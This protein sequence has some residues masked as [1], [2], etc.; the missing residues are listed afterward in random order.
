MNS[1]ESS[2]SSTGLAGMGRRKPLFSLLLP[3][4]VAGGME[5]RDATAGPEIGHYRIRL[6]AD[7]AQRPTAEP[8]ES[9]SGVGDDWRLAW[10]VTRR[11]ELVDPGPEL[12][13][14]HGRA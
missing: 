5:V 12:G 7:Q 4:R 9:V 10:Q 14:S 1:P 13:V 8:P 3:E 2:M 6:T 11:H